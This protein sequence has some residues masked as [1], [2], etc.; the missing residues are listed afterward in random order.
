MSLTQEDYKL[1]QALKKDIEFL[2]SQLPV[3]D[4]FEYVKPSCLDFTPPKIEEQSYVIA[5]CN[6]ESNLTKG[7]SYLV[8]EMYQGSYVITNDSGIISDYE[9]KYFTTAQQ[10]PKEWKPKVGEW[11]KWY[12]GELFLIN[13][14]LG[15]HFAADNQNGILIDADI[16]SCTKPT[17]SEIQAHLTKIAEKRYKKGDKIK[18]PT[19]TII[20]LGE[21]FFYDIGRLWANCVNYPV[22]NDIVVWEHGKWATIINE[23]KGE[24]YQVLTSDNENGYEVLVLGINTIGKAEQ[25][26]YAIQELLKTL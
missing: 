2:Y 6:W 19:G 12:N 18:I 15:T 14:L 16:T 22:R 9:P 17:P 26:K 23:S 3:N 13:Y 24:R 11:V 20:E 21:G 7:K 1:L 5:E 10:E 25:I 4:G 8:R